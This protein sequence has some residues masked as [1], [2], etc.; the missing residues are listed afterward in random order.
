MKTK[1]LFQ[2]FTEAEIDAAKRV[3]IA[4]RAASEYDFETDDRAVVRRKAGA[5]MRRT[6]AT[7]GLLE[8]FER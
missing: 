3:L 4:L 1:I 8:E 2:E 7:L 6:Q 5:S